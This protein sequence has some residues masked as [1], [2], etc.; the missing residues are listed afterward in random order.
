MWFKIFRWIFG[1]IGAAA[2]AV[3]S[4]AMAVGGAVVGAIGAAVNVI[5]SVIGAVVNVVRT[6]VSTVVRQISMR[7]GSYSP[8]W[9]LILFQRINFRRALLGQQ[10]ADAER[11]RIIRD[12]DDN[13]HNGIPDLYDESVTTP[14]ADFLHLKYPTTLLKEKDY[15]RYLPRRLGGIPQPVATGSKGLILSETVSNVGQIVGVKWNSLN[16]PG[17]VDAPLLACNAMDLW[18]IGH[19]YGG[20]QLTR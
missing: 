6:L 15:V 4:G 13:D 20:G 18:K 1:G 9:D 2:G 11:D 17:R 7:F 19:V 12:L 8:A 16:P 10:Q 5:S 3:F 14:G